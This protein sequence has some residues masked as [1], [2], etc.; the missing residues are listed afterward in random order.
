MAEPPWRALVGYSTAAEL[1]T[2][3]QS[4]LTG[5][6]YRV[7]NWNPGSRNRV[8]W[9]LVSAAVERLYALAAEVVR[10]GFHPWADG[11]W[12][13][14]HAR[15]EGITPREART[16][17]GT[18]QVTCSEPL[19]LAPGHTFATPPNSRRQVIRFNVREATS[20]VA[21][22]NAVPIEAVVAGVEGNV[23]VGT[24]VVAEN[25]PAGITS[26][27][28]AADWLT[29]EGLSAETNAQLRVRIDAA[30][31]A[32]G[33][34][35]A[36]QY[37]AWALE[38]DGAVAQARA[39][40]VRGPCSVDVLVIGVE[41][42]PSDELL[43]TVNDYI[44]EQKQ[45]CRDLLVRGPTVTTATVVATLWLRPDAPD[46]EADVATRAAE[47]VQALFDPDDGAGVAPLGIGVSL[48]RSGRLMDALR[49][50]AS[51]ADVVDR[52]DLT[53]PASDVLVAPD[54][55]VR[56]SAAPTITVRRYTVASDGSWAE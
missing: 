27:E 17:Q 7:N 3:I 30:R 8:R 19:T 43:T 26:V 42:A 47:R 29:R 23:A 45:M 49:G 38:A 39:L 21:G 37:E 6:G 28:N 35:T 53:S 5:W 20:C 56:L 4:T 1:L 54:G 24:I 9:E 52:V 11:E 10:Q 36:E 2:G 51:S 32:G 31:A 18:L 40:E 55:M 14:E 33:G 44:V 15:A 46:L 48:R 12:L 34:E 25:V 22:E 13:R 41:G 16:T 50:A